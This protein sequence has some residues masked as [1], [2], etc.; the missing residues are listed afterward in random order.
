MFYGQL[1]IGPGGSGKSTYCN[2]VGQ[3]M[4]SIGRPVCVVNLDC[5]NLAPPY[6]PLIDIRDLVDHEA[7]MHHLNLGPNG[8]IL[9]SIEYLLENFDWLV[10]AI[11]EKA[12]GMYILFDCPGQVEVYSDGAMAALAGR[13]V[14]E[15][16]AALVAVHLVDSHF[17]TDVSKFISVALTS[18][19]CMLQLELP[20]LNVLSKADL[21]SRYDVPCDLDDL[22]N[23]DDAGALLEAL[24]SSKSVPPRLKRLNGALAGLLDEFSLVSFSQLDIQSKDSVLAMI[25]LADRANGYTY[26]RLEAEN[27]SIMDVI[28]RID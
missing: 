25:R 11:R 26:G 13:L 19:S 28:Q 27:S 7:A 15:C 21:L 22:L 4:Q 10:D 1:V 2:G 18:L 8:A 20:H 12:Q 17:V 9:Y 3:M 16:G 24:N 6:T 14:K 23:L 5:N